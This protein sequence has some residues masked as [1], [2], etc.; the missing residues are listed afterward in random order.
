MRNDRFL[1]NVVKSIICFGICTVQL[2]IDMGPQQNKLG[3][4]ESKIINLIPVSFKNIISPLHLPLFCRSCSWWRLPL[5]SLCLYSMIRSTGLI[6]REEPFRELRKPRANSTKS[7]SNVLDS[8]SVWR[9]VFLI[10]WMKP[11]FSP[12]RISRCRDRN[13]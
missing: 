5:H 10:E 4:R 2:W 7:C 1:W 13:Y 3:I 11:L 8:H 9:Q 6:P 12:S